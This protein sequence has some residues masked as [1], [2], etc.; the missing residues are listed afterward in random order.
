MESAIAETVPWKVH[1]ER[2][3][4]TPENMGLSR[5]A[6]LSYRYKFKGSN[7]NKKTKENKFKTL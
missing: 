2:I 1:I 7:K 4:R 5:L 6:T 3:A